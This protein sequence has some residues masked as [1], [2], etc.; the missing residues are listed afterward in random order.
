MTSAI[1]EVRP[2]DIGEQM[3]SAYLDYAM[4]VITA[5]A[6]PDVCDGLKPVQRRILYAMHQMGL[7]SDRPHRKSAR[8]VGEV[9]GKYHPHGDAAVYH[10][11]VRMAQDF[12]TRYP[13]VDGQGNFGSIDGDSPAAMRYTEVRMTEPAETLLRDI[14]KDTVDFGPN[15]DGSLKEPLVLP[16]CL[17]N[18][19][20]N[21]GSGIAVG[22][23]TSIPPHNL[24]EI[25]DALLYVVDRIQ[26]DQ[27]ISLDKLMEKVH[28]PDFPTGGLLYRYRRAAGED[29]PIDALRRAYVM[30]RGKLV[31]RAKTHTEELSHGRHAVIVTEIPY[32]INKSSLVKRLAELA[33]SQRIDGISDL[34]DESDRTGM[35][36]VIELKRSAQPQKVL[37]QLFS[38]SA[39]QTTFGVNLV[40]LVDGQPQVLSL[41]KALRLYLDHRERVVVRR[42]RHELQ[43]ARHREHVLSGLRI[44]L[45]N[46]DEVISVIR[47]SRTAETASSN[48]QRRFRLTPTQAEAILEMP[49]RRLAALERRKIDEEYAQVC[50]RIGELEAILGDRAN[51]LSLIKDD[52]R[53]LKRDHADS[54]RTMI[55]DGSV[56]EFHERDLV[57]DENVLITVSGRGYIK[58]EGVDTYRTQQ[59]GGRGVIGMAMREGD[60][61][62]HLLFASTLDELLLFTSLGH[63]FRLDTHRVPEAERGGKGVALQS[64]IDLRREERVTALVALP[65][66]VG[67]GDD[68]E[69]NGSQYVVMTTRGGI[70]KR[71]E[72]AEFARVR[73]SGLRAIRLEEGDEV[74]WARLT[75]GEQDLLL[76]SR[77]GR[78]I[79]FSELQVRPS[80]RTAGGVRAMKLADGD[81]IAA[82]D[83]SGSG[84]YVCVISEHGYGKRTALDQYSERGR[85][86]VGV[87]AARTSKRTGALVA[88]KLVDPG[89]EIVAVSAAGTVVRLAL[90]SVPVMGRSTQGVRLV[91][92]DGDDAVAAI[93]YIA[94][95]GRPGIGREQ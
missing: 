84:S 36:L 85:A 14:G 10:A 13:L 67:E 54:R 28:G 57:Q 50:K 94:R 4:S 91:N 33:R 40:A 65:M 37:N 30:G 16:A 53:E 61:V 17:P 2:V 21:G 46:L 12:S 15:F 23:A 25:C 89:R 20:V 9:L 24:G 5:R 95:D 73:A 42:T 47:R 74:G 79:R 8:V 56:G 52:L 48:L 70:V 34:R 86:G 62:R 66:G 11:M 72:R 22:M 39:L 18:L 38:R 87:R 69:Q 90:N 92:V 43:A 55:I 26:R 58:R 68:A 63:V 60:R 75:D 6:L 44:A 93:A 3:R 78:A 59:R 71:V 19:L 7:R 83:T 49:L 35:R 41:E 64:L 45:D 27:P 32:Q 77:E 76:V 80:G 82:M 29:D 51:V 1:G 88:A 31:V 81:E